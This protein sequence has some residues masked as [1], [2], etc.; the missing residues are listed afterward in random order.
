MYK[1]NFYSLGRIENEIRPIKRKGYS[2]NMWYYYQDTNKKWYAIDPMTGLAICNGESRRETEETA[3][4]K[5]LLQK[6]DKYIKT[7]LYTEKCSYWYK[8]QVK[9]NII[10]EL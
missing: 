6:I 4:S 3:H 1:T 5:E 10:T 8:L 2:D 9:F 7:K